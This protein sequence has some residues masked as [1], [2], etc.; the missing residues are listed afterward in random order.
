MILTPSGKAE[1]YCV[2]YAHVKRWRGQTPMMILTG[3]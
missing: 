2:R 3:R 1:R